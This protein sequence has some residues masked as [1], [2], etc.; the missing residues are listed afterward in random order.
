[1]ALS[2]KLTFRNPFRPGAGH[3][4]PYLAGRKQEEAE[5]RRLL[6]QTTIMENMVLTGLRGVGKTV[7]LE[8]FRPIAVEEKWLWVGTDLSESTSISEAHIAERLITDLSVVTRNMVIG[9]FEQPAFGFMGQSASEELTLSY[10]RLS[11]VFAQTP[12]LIADK[13]KAVFHFVAPHIAANGRHGVVFAYDEAQNMSDHAGKEQF[14]LSILLDVFQSIQRQGVPFMLLLVGLPTLFPKLVAARTYTERMFRVLFL[15]QLNEQES[16]EAVTRPISDTKCPVKFTEAAIK[17]IVGHSGGYPYF[18][19][20]MCREAYDTWLQK[21]ADGDVP[22][23]PVAE[24]TRKLDNDFFAGRWARV[25]DRQQQLLF[26]IAHLDTANEEFTI[27]DIFEESEQ[28]LQKP[29]G[30]S[31]INQ[32]LVTL[33]T[34]GL[35]YKDRHGKYLFAVPLMVEF[36]RRTM[37]GS[38]SFVALP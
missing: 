29:F 16:R 28:V 8:S 13:L 31:Q 19:Q 37:G 25:T 5:F 21:N 2:S 14:P 38:S 12:G 34:A 3:Q 32:M 23:V 18:I 35:I 6:G 24:I 33:I 27:Q 15:K 20:F 30:R 36:I 11:A 1:M 26:V 4:P 17:M 22:N 10:D 9:N 7:L